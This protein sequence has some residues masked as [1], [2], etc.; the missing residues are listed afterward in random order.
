MGGPKKWIGKIGDGSKDLDLKK[1]VIDIDIIIW[2][3]LIRQGGSGKVDEI[4]VILS[5]F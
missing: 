1:M 4:F 3:K 2:K 5:H